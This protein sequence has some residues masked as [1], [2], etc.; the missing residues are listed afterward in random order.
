MLFWAALLLTAFLPSRALADE[1]KEI[2]FHAGLL[3]LN[4]AKA[5]PGGSASGSS[6]GF[7]FLHDESYCLSLGLDV[8]LMKPKDTSLDSL[9]P[10]TKTKRSM[11][12]SSVLGVARIGQN[13]GDLRPYFLLGFGVHF[14][15]VRIEGAPAA[16]FGW[17]DTGTTE[18]RTL[19]DADGRALAIKISGGADYAVNDNFLAGLFLAFNSMGGATYDFTEQGKALGL[20]G[21]SGA[22]T[23]ITFGLNLTGRF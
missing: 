9:L 16:G 19:M 21:K 12:S 15:N 13:E 1:S 14:T 22:M 6:Y 5:V 18:K 3:S 4:A 20:T 23:A 17:A 7:R 8:D 10:N 11:A 2:S